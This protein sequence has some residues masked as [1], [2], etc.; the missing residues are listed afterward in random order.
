MFKSRTPCKNDPCKMQRGIL[1]LICSALLP[2][3]FLSQEDDY[4]GLF[5][6]EEYEILNIKDSP[7]DKEGIEV[8][9]LGQTTSSYSAVPTLNRNGRFG[10]INHNNICYMSAFITATFNVHSFRKVLFACEPENATTV[11]LAEV[12]AKLQTAKKSISTKFCLMPTLSLEMKWAF[13]GFEDGMEFVGKILDML[14]KSVKSIYNTSV[15]TNY[16]LE[17][18]KVLLKTKD[19][20]QNLIIIMPT[21]ES[22]SDAIQ[23]RFPSQ[24]DY[25]IEQVDF[26]EYEGKIAH[27]SEKKKEFPVI[28]EEF[29]VN[30]P[31]IIVF[32][33]GRKQFNVEFDQT[34]MELDF[35][36]IVPG[37]EDDSD[38]TDYILQSFCY[39]IPG[40]YIS[41]ARDFT[42]DNT[43]GIWYQ[44]DDSTVSVVTTQQE[45]D[46][47]NL[48]TKANTAAT[49]AFYVRA[50]C[51]VTNAAESEPQIP[52][53]IIRIAKLMLA[54]EEIQD[55]RSE[56][57]QEKKQ[58]YRSPPAPITLNDLSSPKSL[59]S[60]A[61]ISSIPSSHL[62]S[63]L[64]EDDKKRTQSLPSPTNNRFME[65]FPLDAEYF[66]EF[67]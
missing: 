18:S 35:E 47:Q 27:F 4:F 56:L 55:R 40:H 32:G 7:F 60:I 66:P 42:V 22:I 48:K 39:H 26:H 16:Y 54:L 15:R 8:S 19:V 1:F 5:D 50:D 64:N 51:V 62:S 65:D 58:Y 6:E 23:S 34:P 17:E 45:Q 59:D 9:R 43:D 14:P 37:L 53:R 41:Y 36:I 3:A 38:S 28:S 11:M 63:I 44:Y 12:F 10:L 46:Y 20:D 57:S 31:E 13:G 52:E 21:F 61:A 24:F 67:D 29:I 25:S 2:F 49:L 30:R 33:I